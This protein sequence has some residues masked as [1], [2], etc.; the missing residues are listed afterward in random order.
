MSAFNIEECKKIGERIREAR[1]AKNMSQS[2]LAEKA[3]VSLPLISDIETGKTGMRL[4][5][6]VAIVKALEVSADYLL[7]TNVPQVNASV[8]NEFAD[9]LSDCSPE[10]TASI[11]K[12]VKELKQTFKVK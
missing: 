4:Y 11:I 6:F 8:Q 1:L 12:I 3:G 9:L 10:E 5:S 2:D 7:L